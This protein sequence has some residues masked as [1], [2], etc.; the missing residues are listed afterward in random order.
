LS[1]QYILY[2]SPHSLF[3]YKVALMLRLSGQRF[4]FRYISFQK[5][6][7]RS[8][9][10]RALSRWGQVPV[11][12]H[13]SR[14]LL[15][16]S[17]ILEYLSEALNAFRASDADAQLIVREWLYWDVD[18]LTAPVAGCYREMLA[19]RKLLPLTQDP[20]ILDHH[21]RRADAAFSILDA[22][23]ADREFL[24]HSATIADI[25]CYAAVAFAT[26]SE[27]EMGSYANMGRWATRLSGLPGFQ[28][29]FDLLSMADAEVVA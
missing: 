17:A 29:P 25:S 19:K 15:Q 27:F 28:L 4:F 1:D 22:E 5:G 23:L 12:R 13:G 9:E 7:N 11:L 20:V 14:V 21:R 10:F 16:S 3:T 26:L 8:P 24:V 18:R 6:V 2:G